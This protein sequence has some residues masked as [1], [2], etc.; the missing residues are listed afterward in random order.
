MEAPMEVHAG[1]DGLYEM[2]WAQPSLLLSCCHQIWVA[3]SPQT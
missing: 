2:M 3:A 1:Q